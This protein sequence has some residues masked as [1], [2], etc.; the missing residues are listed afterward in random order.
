MSKLINRLQEKGLINPP[1]FLKDTVQ[2]LCI[3]GSAAYGVSNV[4]SDVDV[5][6]YCIP[7]K[8]VLFPHTTGY[9]P[10]LD[11]GIP[12]FDQWQQHHINDREAGKEYDF[13]VYSILKYFRL[14]MDGNPNMIDSLFIPR[15][16]IIHTTKVHE[17]VRENRKLFLSKKVWPK[18]KGYAYSQLHKMKIKNPDPTSKRYPSIQKYG[19]DVKFAYHVVRLLNECQQILEEEDLDLQRNREQ[20]KSIRRGEWT[21]DQVIK[22][23]T[24]KELLLE[25]VHQKSSLPN[26][27]NINKVKEL[28]LNSLEI[29]YGSLDSVIERKKDIDDLVTD[30]QLL[31]DRYK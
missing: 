22:Y 12:T 29:Y 11:K 8:S 13:S 26:E 7:P 31:I 27:P 28:Y 4:E 3:T 24:E 19:Y 30:L 5:Y 21:Q 14:V 18:F 6:G 1:S 25:K 15:N 17:L 2:Y 10:G 23:F 9:I 20:L 16:L